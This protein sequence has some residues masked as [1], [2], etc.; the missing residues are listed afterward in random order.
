[1]NVNSEQQK[2][3]RERLRGLMNDARC[4]PFHHEFGPKFSDYD[5]TYAELA[6]TYLGVEVDDHGNETPVASGPE[7]VARYAVISGDE[8]YS[9][10]EL[11]DRIEP[12]FNELVIERIV[13]LDS[14]AD[15]PFHL[16]ALSGEEFAAL[17]GL[18][19][20]NWMNAETPEDEAKAVNH[21][22]I[23]AD[24][25]AL[26]AKFPLEAFRKWADAHGEDFYYEEAGL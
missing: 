26:R 10:I 7:V 2:G 6:A 1:V 17:C 12:E 8:T 19:A 16:V 25:T 3:R 23:Y 13:D 22:G 20:P 5:D 24:W 4:W 21:G 18:V 9:F 14:G 15:V 11:S